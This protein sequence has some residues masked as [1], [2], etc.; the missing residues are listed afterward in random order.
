MLWFKKKKGPLV[1]INARPRFLPESPSFAEQFI[2]EARRQGRAVCHWQ[3]QRPD[4]VLL[5]GKTRY[6]DLVDEYRKKGVRFVQRIDGPGANPANPTV[7]NQN[8]DTYH[9]MDALIFQTK[10]CR[11][12]WESLLPME[13]PAYIV[14]NGA[15]EKIFSREGKKENFGFKRLIVTAARWRKWKNL[16][17]M[18]ELFR[19]LKRDDL[20]LVV[21]G[22]GAEVPRDKRILATGKLSHQQMARVFRAADLL[23][24]LPWFE[25]CPKVVVQALVAG[26][27]VVCSSNGGTKELV[28]DCGRLVPN[29]RNTVKDYY[30]PNPVEIEQGVKV[31]NDLLENRERVRPR[32]DLFLSA[33]VEGYFQVFEKVLDKNK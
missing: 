13:K 11:E 18:I 6:L 31:V 4:L 15:D 25:W 1:G 33:M 28:Q 12:A 20:G 5:I 2:K 7:D 21:A 27:P 3:K 19:N 29:Q 10:F 30:S 26:L 17:Q 9:K 32:P 8:W 23:L 16:S 22:T 14:F 24:Y